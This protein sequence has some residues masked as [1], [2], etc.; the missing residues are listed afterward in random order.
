M[1]PQLEILHLEDSHADC[2]LIHAILKEEGIA[3]DI[4]HCDNREKFIEKLDG[5]NYDLIFADCTLPNFS[6]L[7]ALELARQ[8]APAIPFIFVSGSI[9][10]DAAIESL[11]KGATDYVLKDRL[12][13]L[14]PAVRRAMAESDERAR[15]RQMEERLQLAQRLEAVGALAGG[16]AHDFNNILAIIRG[17]VALLRMGTL[18]ADRVR[19]VSA[20]IDHA[21]QRGA[22]LV[23]QLLAFARKSEGAFTATDINGCVREIVTMLREAI[24]RNITFD[25]QLEEGLPEIF[26]DPGQLD[27]VLINLATNARDA[28]P[29]GGRITFAT[30]CVSSDQV[31]FSPMEGITD[32]LCLRVIDTGSGMDEA[33]RLHIFEPFFTTKAKG[34]GTGLGMPVVYGLMQSHN[35]IID[36]QSEVGKGTTISLF[37][38]IPHN[39][40]GKSAESLVPSTRSVEGAETVLIVDD[41]TD[42]SYFVEIILKSNGYTVLVARS[43]KEAIELLRSHSGPIDLLFSDIG[44]PDLDGFE[45]STQARQIHP[46][47][48]V[49]LTSGYS[50]GI[51]KT[52][53]AEQGIDCFITKPYDIPA[54]LHSIRGIFDKA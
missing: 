30:Q 49:M 10:E 45:L 39:T 19:E 6:G 52:R 1:K 31:P 18:P 2:E 40:Q 11:H 15:N 33:T 17:H 42:I 16:V 47:L 53:L 25:L 7:H 37:F 3:C 35:G 43:A 44:L 12:S 22:E 8:H 32:Y 26:A 23:G 21:A 36:I 13:R 54:L 38:P 34:K 50:D 48:K 41:E 9:G 27:R 5:K 14:V 29:D 51:V 4:E 28:M 46:G 24:S 20:I